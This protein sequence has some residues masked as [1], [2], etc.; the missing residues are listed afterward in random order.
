MGKKNND[1]SHTY[2]RPKLDGHPEKLLKF[3]VGQSKAPEASLEIL[4]RT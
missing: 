4:G 3:F 1:V 2:T